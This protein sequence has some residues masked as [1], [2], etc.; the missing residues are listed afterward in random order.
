[1]TL[2][3]QQGG[4]LADVQIFLKTLMCK[5]IIVSIL[6]KLCPTVTWQQPGMPDTIKGAACPL[7]TVLLL[8][9]F[10]LTL[11]LFPF[12]LFLPIPLPPTLHMLMAGLYSSP[13]FFFLSS[14][15]IVS[16]FH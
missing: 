1:M 6:S 4:Q 5:T 7:L 11:H 9:L 3:L 10:S 2:F 16:F 15:S 13:L 8:L 12:V 14:L